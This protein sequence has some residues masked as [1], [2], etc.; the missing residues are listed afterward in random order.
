MTR[1]DTSLSQVLQELRL[2]KRPVSCAGRRQ[3]LK[4][5][6]AFPVTVRA[7]DRDGRSDTK[8][9][10][11]TVT[12]VNRPP[13]LEAVG[14]FN[15]TPGQSISFAARA[16]DPDLPLNTI[17]YSVTGNAPPGFNLNPATGQ[18]SWTAS[19]TSDPTTYDFLVRATDSGSPA[20]FDSKPVTIHVDLPVLELVEDDRFVTQATYTCDHRRQRGA[21]AVYV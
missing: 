13:V 6:A 9:F 18:F 12:E 20:L 14:T 5:P 10:T 15:L 8:S 17:T 21:V 2:T 3:R 7:D 19:A 16:S 11:I 1:Y 4:A